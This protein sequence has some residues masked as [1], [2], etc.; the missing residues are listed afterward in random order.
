MTTITAN[1]LTDDSSNGEGDLREPINQV[2]GSMTATTYN[3]VFANNPTAPTV[4]MDGSTG[5]IFVQNPDR[6]E[7]AVLRQ[8]LQ[9]LGN[10]FNP[11]KHS[12][13]DNPTKG[14]LTGPGD[15]FGSNFSG[16]VAGTLAFNQ[17]GQTRTHALSAGRRRPRCRLQQPRLVRP[18][19]EQTLPE[20]GPSD[21][22]SF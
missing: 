4:G 5:S 7:Q 16:V 18:Q 10:G 19:P 15:N 3:I 6:S 8:D 17:G 11:N 22:G 9:F 2:N 1:S 21:V 13:P 14:F 20:G 12:I